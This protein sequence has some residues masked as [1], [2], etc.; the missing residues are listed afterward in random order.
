MNDPRPRLSPSPGTSVRMSEVISSMS[1][2]LDIVEGQPEGHA[3][4][5]CLLGMRL[6]EELRLDAAQRSALFYALLLK[7]LGCAS[8]A[9]KICYLFGADDQAVKK[10][11]KT[12]DWPRVTETAKYILRNVSPN[13]SVFSKLACFANLA[14]GGP[15]VARELVKI[16][17]ERGALI[18]RSLD[19]PEDAVQAIRN[20]DEHWD[21]RGHPDGLRRE[22][23]PV[24]ARILGIAQTI[25]VY[26]TRDG[27]DAALDIARERSGTWFDPALVKALLSIGRDGAFWATMRSDV[28]RRFLA[29]YEPDDRIVTADDAQLDNVCAAFGQVIDAKSPWTACHSQGVSDIAVGIAS[30]LRMPPAEVRR[31]KRAGLLHDIGKLGVSNAILDKP[32]RLEPAE[33]EILK[34]HPAQTLRILERVGCFA[35]FADLAASHHER[36]DGKGYFRGLGADQL[37]PSARTLVVA[38]MYEAL[39]AQRPYRKDLSEGEVHE[40]LRKNLGAGICPSAYDALLRFLERTKYTTTAIAA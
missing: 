13:G 5:S 6:A 22:E 12:T 3:V 2:A 33:F 40:I 19:L 20:L 4:R 38:D 36:L 8:N 34:L 23:I 29:A 9:A 7:D 15:K 27:L 16:R 32:G 37:C 11:F 1:Y 31:V 10:D 17:C 21:G 26:F 25:E 30:E 24:L 28:P 18:A 14:I 39:A 35:D